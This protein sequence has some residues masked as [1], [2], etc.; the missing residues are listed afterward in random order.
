MRAW[1]PGYA[2]RHPC[3]GFRRAW[4]A[5]R[6]DESQWVNVKR[7]HRLRCQEGIQVRAR[8]PRKRA[9]VSSMSPVVA[10]GPG[11]VWAIDFQLTVGERLYR[12]V[13]QPAAPR[14]PQ[15]QPLEHPAR[16][17]GSHRRLQK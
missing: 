13:Q 5:L 15:P 16:G 6:Y 1:L 8:S 7:V 9:G 17:P 14:V 4:A 10:D 11:V 12:V 2:T 3:H